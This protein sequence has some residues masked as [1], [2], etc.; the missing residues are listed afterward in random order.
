M[1]PSAPLCLALA[2]AL[3]LCLQ[4]PRRDTR[5]TRGQTRD[6]Q[7]YLDRVGRMRVHLRIIMA[8][9]RTVFQRFL[10]NKRKLQE[11]HDVWKLYHLLYYYDQSGGKEVQVTRPPDVSYFEQLHKVQSIVTKQVDP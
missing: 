9:I 4:A 3:A 7:D 2:L 8:L 1:L 6:R 5:D 11:E 10:Q